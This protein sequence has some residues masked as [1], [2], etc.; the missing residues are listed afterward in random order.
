MEKEEIEFIKDR[1]KELEKFQKKRN[2]QYCL[3]RW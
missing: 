1:I 3:V 2:H